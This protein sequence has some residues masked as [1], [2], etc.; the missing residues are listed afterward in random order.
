MTNL[1]V[2]VNENDVYNIAPWNGSNV[3]ANTAEA[4]ALKQLAN[5]VSI[6]EG[7]MPTGLTDFSKHGLLRD[8]SQLSTN[9]QEPTE[10]P[11][12]NLL[13]NSTG[14]FF[15]STWSVTNTS[16]E[17]HYI[18]ADLLKT[19]SKIRVKYYERNINRYCEPKTIRVMA[20]ND[21]A[22]EWQEISLVSMPARSGNVTVSLGVA[23]R[24]VRF[25]VEETFM[26][27][28]TNNNLYFSGRNSASLK[29]PTS[30][31]AMCMN[32]C[33]PLCRP[34]VLASLTVR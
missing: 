16:G 26:G 5:D 9:K 22:G 21:A 30:L 18:Q 11:I 24:Y 29:S 3:I 33:K 17:K 34:S 31:K 27:N 15:H 28:L 14:T 25:V 1:Y 10:E 20:T 32:C 19:V 8:A 12:A 2:P 23:Y 6:E 4:I 7:Y 13:D